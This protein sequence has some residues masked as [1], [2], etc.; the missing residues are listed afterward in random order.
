MLKKDKEKV[1]DEVWTEDRIREFLDQLP[2]A[3]VNTDFHMLW[4]AYQG[5]RAEH[6]EIFLGLFKAQ[7]R[8]VNATNNDDQSV[9]TIA[10]EHSQS[11]D[12]VRILRD[13][14]AQ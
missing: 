13:A 6:F 3:G 11:G 12:Y 10:L 8:D 4:K 5:M 7:N 2:P 1:I 14:G 9:L